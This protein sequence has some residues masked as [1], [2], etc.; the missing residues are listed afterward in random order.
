MADVIEMTGRERRALRKMADEYVA[1]R[2]ER[3]RMMRA[4]SELYWAHRNGK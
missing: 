1:E 4:I 2:E 3:E